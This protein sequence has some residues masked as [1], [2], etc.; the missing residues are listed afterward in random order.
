MNARLTRARPQAVEPL[1]PR[2]RI[3]HTSGPDRQDAPRG[4][5]RLLLVI[6]LALLALL[7]YG[8]VRAGWMAQCTAPPPGYALHWHA[9]PGPDGT[10]VARC[11]YEPM[12][13]V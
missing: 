1:D 9:Q 3:L 6:T 10:P 12:P 2:R 4:A 5:W 13:G 8:K 7:I 11:E